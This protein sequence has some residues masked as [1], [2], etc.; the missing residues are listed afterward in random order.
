MKSNR[1]E[2]PQEQSVSSAIEYFRIRCVTAVQVSF[3]TNGMSFQVAFSS[4]TM[5]YYDKILVD[6]SCIPVLPRVVQ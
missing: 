4:T 1:Q 3:M 5:K 6:D 2:Q